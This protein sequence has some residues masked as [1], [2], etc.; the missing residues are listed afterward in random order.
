MV[1]ADFFGSAISLKDGA[2]TALDVTHESAVF[3]LA[4]AEKPLWL[5]L[6]LTADPNLVYDVAA[7]LTAASDATAQLVCK[8][9]YAI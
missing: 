7:T 3:S 6:G 4:N 1:D 9:A 8:G 2:L 5:A